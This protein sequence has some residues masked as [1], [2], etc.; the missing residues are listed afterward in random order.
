VGV[1]RVP[2]L[3]GWHEETVL[4]GHTTERVRCGWRKVEVPCGTTTEQVCVGT[5]E[6]VRRVGWQAD[7][8]EVRPATTRIV[9]EPV[10][11]PCRRV[12]VVP[13]GAAKGAPVAGT[14]E[15]LTD[16]ELAEA[17]ARATTGAR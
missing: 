14:T 13:D 7:V 1:Q 6:V 8:R 4:C 11:H 3:L 10:A 17:Y 16:S 9:R 12:T 2:R 15:V 5:R